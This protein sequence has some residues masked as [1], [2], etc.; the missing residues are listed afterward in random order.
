MVEK[1]QRNM[2]D[3]QIGIHDIAKRI[4]NYPE[5]RVERLTLNGLAIAGEAGEVADEIKKINWYDN[6]KLTIER[7]LNMKNELGDLLWHLLETA[8]SVGYEFDEIVD[9]M[10]DKTCAR[11]NIPRLP[12]PYRI[13][14]C[15][16]V[17]EFIY[18]NKNVISSG[19]EKV[20]INRLHALQKTMLTGAIGVL[21]DITLN[22]TEIKGVGLVMLKEI[23]AVLDTK[24][25]RGLR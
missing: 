3:V 4:P 10:I 16:S 9:G 2:L 6:G 7:R 24:H 23:F 8:T 20:L 18:Q 17:G 1:T 11:N 22:S 14:N 13:N 25:Y 21:T 5:N 15:M 12:R 19:L